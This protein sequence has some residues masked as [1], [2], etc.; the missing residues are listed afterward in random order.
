MI[1]PEFG[2]RTELA[3]A[4]VFPELVRYSALMDFME[5]TASRRFTSKR[6]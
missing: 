5:T 3:V 6:G 1:F 4:V 2:I